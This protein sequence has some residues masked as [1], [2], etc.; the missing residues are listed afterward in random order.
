MMETATT[1]AGGP[2]TSSFSFAAE[3]LQDEEEDATL[4]DTDGGV[5]DPGEEPDVH[6]EGEEDTPRGFLGAS[7]RASSTRSFGFSEGR[8]TNAEQDASDEPTS[9]PKQLTPAPV[10]TAVSQKAAIVPRPSGGDLATYLEEKVLHRSARTTRRPAPLPAT[11]TPTLIAT[12]ALP[13][14]KALDER[15]AS[16]AG[17]NKELQDEF[18]R[19]QQANVRNTTVAA[20]REVRLTPA[21]CIRAPLALSRTFTSPFI[22]PPFLPRRL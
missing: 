21:P 10:A 5:S 22:P 9:A 20:Q 14:I 6:D 18:S 11:P 15:V 1:V 4:E 13:Q 19:L 3:A 12:R 16:F 2:S 8:R 7:S 17:K